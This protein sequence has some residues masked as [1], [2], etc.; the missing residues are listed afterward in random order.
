MIEE[1][2][3]WASANEQVTGHLAI[4]AGAEVENFL[5]EPA[6]LPVSA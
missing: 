3:A 2:L 1:R 6:Y 4:S 5:L